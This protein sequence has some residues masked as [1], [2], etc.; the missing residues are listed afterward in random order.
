MHDSPEIHEEFIAFEMP[1]RVIETFEIIKVNHHKSTGMACPFCSC[2][3]GFQL[4][5]K[6]PFIAEAGK[7]VDQREGPKFYVFFMKLL[8]L[9]KKI[10]Y[11]CSLIS[12]S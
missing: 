12:A 6:K 9:L 7:V 10:M 11:G 2:H 3:L 8:D 4:H 1:E 5:P